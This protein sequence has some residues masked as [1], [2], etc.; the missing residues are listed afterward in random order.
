MTTHGDGERLEPSTDLSWRDVNG[1]LVIVDTRRGDYHVP[2]T[3]GARVF[4]AIVNGE[5]PTTIAPLVAATHAVAATEVQRDVEA[6]I[7]TLAA[8]GLLVTR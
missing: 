6:F 3:L 7:A 2:N 5:D 1:E 8:K 4:T